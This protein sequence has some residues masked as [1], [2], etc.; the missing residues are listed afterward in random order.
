MKKLCYILMIS[1]L[2]TFVGCEKND[3][4]STTAYSNNNGNEIKKEKTTTLKLWTHYGGW[5]RSINEFKKDHPDINIEVETFKFD[6]YVK[7]YLKALSTGEVPDLMVIDSTS[8]GNFNS[9]YGLEDLKKEQYG[10]AKYENDFDKELWNLGHRFDSKEL[11]GIPFATAPL[12]LY[13]RADIMSKYGFPS[14]PEELGKYIENPENW[15]KIARTLK[16]DN[17]YISEKVTDPM[18]MAISQYGYY[19]NNLNFLGNISEFKELLNISKKMKQESLVSYLDLWKEEGV[20]ALKEGKLAM[21]STFGSWGSGQIENWVPEQAGK[22]RVTRLP[23]NIYGWN[24]SS[25]LSMPTGS[26]HKEAAAKFI[27]FYCFKFKQNDLVGSVPGYIPSRNNLK[28][29]EYS[30]KFLGGQKEQKFYEYLMSKTNEHIV[31]PLDEKTLGIWEKDINDGIADNKGAD[32]IM[33]SIRSDIDKT[34]GEERKI[35]LE[36]KNKSQ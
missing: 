9:I 11:I 18:K 27:E 36:N 15:F 13:Y 4:N 12:V 34:L 23:F 7:K 1:F 29:L 5:E 6:D 20:Q 25:I 3:M 19:D 35:L 8:W 24:N 10:I 33:D 30:N 32:A 28:R 22:W 21:I 31:T 17:I 26:K 2:F 14:E 16:K